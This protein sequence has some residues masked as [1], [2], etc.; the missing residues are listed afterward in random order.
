MSSASHDLSRFGPYAQWLHYTGDSLTRLCVFTSFIS[1][2]LAQ[3]L[4]L[5]RSQALAQI[6]GIDGV[7][8]ES[9]GQSVVHF[10]VAPAWSFGRVHEVEAIV[11]PKV[12]SYL[13]VSLKG[14]WQHSQGLQLADP[15]F[16]SPGN[17]DILLDVDVFSD[18][19]LH[20]RR[21]GPPGSPT[22]TETCFGL[23]L[24]GVVDCSQPSSRIVSHHTS[25]LS[26]D[27]LLHRFWEVE[28][29]STGCP[30]WTPEEQSVVF[31]F[32]RR[33]DEGRFVVPLPRKSDTKPLGQS[34]TLAV[35]RFLS[36]ERSLRAKN[37]FPEFSK[38]M[39]EYLQMNHVE[40]VPT[41]DLK[42]LFRES[43]DACR[44][45]ESSSTTKIRAVFDA[46]AKSSSGVLLNDQ[47]LVGPT[48]CFAFVVIGSLLL[49]T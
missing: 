23:V 12:T 15:E 7:S 16:G 46:S 26:G 38:V 34:R 28:E 42:R 30:V 27:D 5:P 10:G 22:A 2:R 48:C 49:R 37:Q 29:L 35:R 47:L 31:N 33:D 4:R 40:L 1:V 9:L 21:P 39:V 14:R 13:P 25:V 18:M 45:K 6:A 3:H 32:H 44:E 36:L 19:L 11:L 41:A 17:V 8:H 43:S 20:G 24:T